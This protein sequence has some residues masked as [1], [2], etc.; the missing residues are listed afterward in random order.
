MW[1]FFLQ[2]IWN[3]KD[4]FWSVSRTDTFFQC[5]LYMAPIEQI[6]G[7]CGQVPWD[8]TKGEWLRFDCVF[9]HFLRIKKEKVG[10]A[11]L[12]SGKFYVL[13]LS[14]NWIPTR[15]WYLLLIKAWLKLLLRSSEI[16]SR[17]FSNQLHLFDCTSLT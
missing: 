13:K 10:Q 17:Y 11:A 6:L 15:F 3:I 2:I 4:Y 12:E 16:Q 14:G 5:L 8:F 1:F 9:S 7:L